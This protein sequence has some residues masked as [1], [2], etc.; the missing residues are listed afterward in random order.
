MS[1]LILQL[2]STII[3]KI[4]SNTVSSCTNSYGDDFASLRINAGGKS[5]EYAYTYD[6]ITISWTNGRRLASFNEKVDMVL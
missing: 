6:D 2:I 5:T 3:L 1:W 4:D